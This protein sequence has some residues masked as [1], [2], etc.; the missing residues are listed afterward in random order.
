MTTKTCGCSTKTCGCCE[1]IQKLTPAVTENRPALPAL[2]YRVGTHGTF[3]STMKARL[4]TMKVEA[5]GADGQT[6]ET[7]RPLTGLTTRDASDPA[8]ALLDGWA[9]VA[10]VL[11]FYQERIA[12]EGYL[13]TATER[14]SVLELARLVGYALR[15]GVA[16]TV[17]LAYTL[18][19][20]QLEPVEIPI[21]ARSQSIP[22]P[23][24]LPQSFETIERIVARSEWNNLQVRLTR[25]PDIPLGRALALE[26]FHVAGTNTNLKKGDTLLFLYGTEARQQIVR[27][28]AE[29]EG[30]FAQDRTWI[31]LAPLPTGTADALPKLDEFIQAANV[32]A[33]TDTSGE[34]QNLIDRAETIRSGTYLGAPAPPPLEW[35]TSIA[36][37]ANDN[38]SD[39]LEGLLKTL[40]DQVAEAV[41]KASQ[42]NDT[43]VTSPD[44]FV[45]TL[46]KEPNEQFA[47]STRLPRTLSKA[48]KEG[49]DAQAQLLV[50]LAPKLKESYYLAWANAEVN[51]ASAPLQGVYAMRVRAGYFGGNAPKRPTYSEGKEPGPA[52][53][54]NPPA[55]WVE[56]PLELDD[57]AVDSVFLENAYESIL[58]G[59]FA[60]VQTSTEGS[61]AGSERQ[62]LNVKGVST[63]PRTAYGITGKS[64]QL[65][66]TKPW[67][68]EA[69]KGELDLGNF[70][71]TSIFAQSEPLTVLPS[72]IATEVSGAEIELA[73]LYDG[74]VSGRWIILSGERADISNVAGVKTS[75][76]LMISGVRQ[77]FDSELPG[78][79]THTTLLLATP[80]A[81]TYKRET[82]T[83]FGNVVTATHGET[84]NEILG[85]GD[86]SQALQTFALKQPP[87]TFVSSPTPAGVKSTLNV[88]VNDVRWLETD[89]LAGLGPKNRN[90]VTKTDDNAG[91][92]L[93]FG[94]GKEGSRLP[95]GVENVKAVYRNGIGKAGNVKADQ[96]SLLQTKP[97]GVKAV[98]NPLRASGGADKENRDQARE[99]APLTVA[100]LDRLVGVQDYTDFTRTFAGIAKAHARRV[101]D[102]R[103]Q[104]V[105][106][107][108]A[109]ADDIPIDPVSDF[110]R[111]LLSALREY[112]DE[113]LSV[114]IDRRELVV[115]VLSANVRIAP[116]YLWEKV[117]LAVR[118][119]LL[120]SFGFPKRALGQPA[121]LC[122]VISVIQNVA[123]VAYVD[124]D[125][126]GGI[127]ERR[128]E[129]DQKGLPTGKRQLL[130]LD[131]LTQA[132]DDI[133]D[134]TRV[135]RPAGPA[136][137]VDANVAAFE[138]GSLRP[139]QLAIFTP[140]VPDT[141]ILN[142]I[143]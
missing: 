25:P 65:T 125:N 62:F 24:E 69:D 33:P 140:D 78:D 100:A 30:Q 96:I 103:R 47:N 1:G 5:P 51:N 113:A 93:V 38:P 54:V 119:A 110:Y 130:T 61:A 126:F 131:D 86:G 112:G 44:D 40:K 15:P 83:I 22:G 95:T 9:T 117:S 18:E 88:Y 70:R 37:A 21:G 59:S 74:L 58:P 121:L 55:E 82:L 134:P 71:T 127:P 98:I 35:A 138:Q 77:G 123:G 135:G 107:T 139:A 111:N 94:N 89:S 12:N 63:G 124:V 106:I 118:A 17:Y 76:L 92:T 141:L 27:T 6:L 68:K 41:A 142:Q 14:R 136:E 85:S 133:V 60:V 48:F 84:R 53:I 128:A 108:I 57:K 13:R 87:L 99:N 105:H 67:R 7:F 90:F 42:P 28:I 19:E 122:E 132:V 143:L 43:E 31:R 104:L 11:T 116:E 72:P 39:K 91:T 120:E 10:D 52:L 75:E 80:T 137:R 36:A 29:V 109:G 2:Q 16:S 79:K 3:F 26:S 56:L 73:G 4:S 102:G 34:A 64:T 49:S 50:N 23:D 129:T 32:L 114:Q 66:F 81:Y 20:K 115:L 101:S 8:I 97:L 46:L 45:K